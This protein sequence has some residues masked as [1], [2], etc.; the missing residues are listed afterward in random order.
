MRIGAVIAV[1]MGVNGNKTTDGVVRRVDE[2]GG[3]QTPLTIVRQFAK[4]LLG[5]INTAHSRASDDG[6]RLFDACT[7][8]GNKRSEQRTP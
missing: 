1:A 6:L 3:F 5:L 2:I 7:F 8:Q 4:K